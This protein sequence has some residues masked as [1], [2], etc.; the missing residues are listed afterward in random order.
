MV[1]NVVSMTGY[2]QGGSAAGGWR[3]IP[4][5]TRGARARRSPR[6]AQCLPAP[7]LRSAAS[8]VD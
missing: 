4:G 2:Q 8:A 6:L 3:A 5:A 1:S 7:S